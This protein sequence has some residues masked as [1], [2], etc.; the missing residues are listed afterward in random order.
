MQITISRSVL[1]EA[2]AVL[3]PLAG[4]NKTLPVLNNIKFV[5][6]GNKIRLQTTDGETSIRK[7]IDA[8]SIDQDGDFLVDC[9]SLNAFVVKTKCDTLTLSIV[10]NTLTVRHAKGKA[11]F[12]TLS[13]QDFV[14]PL[15]DEESTEVTVPANALSSLV[16]IA[17]NFV[18]NDDY[19]P[20]M[21]PIRAI[22][23]NGVLS[24][25][26]TDTRKMF[27][28]SVSLS[29]DTLDVSW[30]IEPCVFSSLVKACKGQDSVVVKVSARNVSYRIGATTIYSQ[31]S[32]ARYPDYKRVI[33]RSHTIDVVCEK[34][35]LADAMQRATLFTED[36][37]LIKLSVQSLSMDIQAENLGKLQKAVETLS[38]SSN[39]E[40]VFGSNSQILLD[41]VNACGSNEITLELKDASAPI[42]VR[43]KDNANRVV[44]FM[45]MAL[46]N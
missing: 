30:Y 38:C 45:P 16:S 43:D 19:R 15:Q 3:S 44:L 22:I 27:V 40:I 35:D 39:Q 42:V 25:V 7:Y 6:K 28:D 20:M 29:A 31:Q 4:K 21:K 14:E 36:N 1:A 41:C 26:A 17:R 13:A 10:D 5:T 32:R 11:S 23:E 12:Q 34:G 33:P 24:I 46:I 18:G 37:N 9:A 8:E 2:L